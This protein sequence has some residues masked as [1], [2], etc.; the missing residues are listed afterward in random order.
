MPVM[1]R[2]KKAQKL[3]SGTINK[4]KGSNEVLE[5]KIP[6]TDAERDY[7]RKIGSR[8]DIGID[9]QRQSKR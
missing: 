9:I 1:P 2:P 3:L 8:K 6:E 7:T 5:Y 4:S